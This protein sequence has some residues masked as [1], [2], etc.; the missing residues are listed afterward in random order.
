MFRYK[1]YCTNFYIVYYQVL[2][3]DMAD[4]VEPVKSAMAAAVI[5]LRRGAHMARA[6]ELGLILRGEEAEEFCQNA[7]QVEF[8][9]SQ[10]EFF[11][12]A[13]R[14]YRANRGKF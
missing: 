2:H 1:A 14:I 11:R 6:T 13:K 3:V 10:L 5:P 8:T 12:R 7:D 4:M 9:P